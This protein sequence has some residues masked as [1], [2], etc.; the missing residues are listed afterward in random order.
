MTIES[1]RALFERKLQELYYIERQLDDF[2]AKLADEATDDD[3]RDFFAGHHETTAEQLDRIEQAFE[4][5]N[6]DPTPRESASLEAL[7]EEREQLTADVERAD[8]DDL[9]DTEIGRAIERLEVTKLETLLELARRLKL[10]SEVT[11]DLE[12]SR[13]E[14][15]NAIET[16][17]ELTASY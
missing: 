5:I 8:L 9:E 13:M 15:E 4:A 6:A 12:Q 1:E 7:I 14:A 17:Q 11:D 10:D 2:Q 3:V 16:A